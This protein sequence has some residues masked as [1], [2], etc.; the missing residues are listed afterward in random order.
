MTTPGVA[1][2]LTYW[3]TT[4]V[5]EVASSTLWRVVRQ[6]K[7]L[8]GKDQWR[9]TSNCVWL[10]LLWNLNICGRQMSFQAALCLCQ[11]KSCFL[12][13]LFL[14]D[15]L[16]REAKVKSNGIVNYE[17]FTQMVTLPP[18]DYWFFFQGKK[19]SKQLLWFELTFK[20]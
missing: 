15:E 17:E 5:M 7:T 3:L 2:T 9:L 8:T 19:T 12:C 6:S 13:F 10:Y 14:V 11:L 1:N 16:F 4:E 18:V 20:L